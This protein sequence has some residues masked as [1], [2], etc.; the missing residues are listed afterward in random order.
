MWLQTKEGLYRHF[1]FANF[2]RAFEFMKRVAEVA[3]GVQHH[4]RWTND[5]DTVEIWLSTHSA[6]DEITQKDHEMA[7]AIDSIASEFIR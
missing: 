4:P 6:G 1:T 7:E 3:E 2:A 5:Y